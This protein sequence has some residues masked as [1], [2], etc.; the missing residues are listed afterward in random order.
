M[1]S[2]SAWLTEAS[3]LL[4]NLPVVQ[5]CQTVIRLP[6]GQLA[7]LGRGMKLRTYAEVLRVDSTAHRSGFF[8]IH[9]H[10]GF[11]WAARREI[12]ETVGF[13]DGAISGGGDHIMAHAF[14]GDWASRCLTQMMGPDSAWHA[15]AVA[16]SKR[17]YAQVQG[18]IG[19]VG[20]T[21]LHLWHGEMHSR[22]YKQ[23]HAALRNSKFDPALDIKLD[24]N[25]CWE[26]ATEKPDLHFALGNYL[27]AR[28]DEAG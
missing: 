13:Y 15:H 3:T 22:L 9:G 26:W 14:A 18:K 28:R 7:Y 25:G 21:A 19:V 11:C 2:N 20:G 5:L 8:K 6:R 1:F 27:A 10:T 17:T 4:D 24:G 16:W 23:R 12:L